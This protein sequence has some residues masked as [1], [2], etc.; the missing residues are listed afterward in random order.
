MTLVHE[1]FTEYAGSEMVVEQLAREWPDAPILAPVARP[2][3]LP[4]DVEPR[5]RSTWLSRL[6]RGSTYAHLLPAL[7]VAMSRLPVPPSDVVIASHHAF[8][9]QVV[10]ATTAPVVAYVHSPARWVWD[11]SMRANE[12]GGRLGAAGLGAFSAAFRPV[13]LRAA[14]RVHTLVG[15]SRAV[16]ERIRDWWGREATVVHPPV[17]TQYYCPD[18]AV[19]REDFFLL[20]G[21]LVPYKRS[22]L[23]VRAARQA[24]VPLVVAG[25]GRARAEVEQLAGPGTTFVGRVD[26][27]GLRDLFRRCRALLMPGVEDFGIV[28]VEAQAC[29][30]PVLAIDAGGAR[31]SVLP[32]VTGEL[33]PAA[34]EDEEV[35][36]WARALASF[37][38]ASY[39][40][41]AI[42]RHAESFSRAHFRGAMADVV[43]RVL[44]SS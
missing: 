35:D 40:P 26:D 14:A 11:P 42:R 21:R 3:V 32:G 31:D 9:T 33:V 29:G 25:E 8:A 5:V 34:G 39:D 27:E 44:S 17:D 37:D 12:A 19:P 30:A 18:P 24:G 4:A 10:H 23:A 38:G 36:V 2:G 28:P 13:D 22:D 7:P 41:A 15:N 43:D 20:A 1:R 6:L 16:A